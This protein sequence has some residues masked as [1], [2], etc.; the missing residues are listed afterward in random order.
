MESTHLS[1]A[2]EL[3]DRIG[4]VTAAEEWGD[5]LNPAQR[6][7]L[8]YLARANAFSRTPSNVA[9]YLCT[10][11]GT[12]SQTLKSLD[13]KGLVVRSRSAEDKRSVSYDLTNQG[14]EV[15]SRVGSFD[16]ALGSVPD[17]EARA[18]TEAL[19]TIGRHMLERRG[20]KTFGVCRTCRHHRREGDG[21]VCA[22]LGIPLTEPAT[23]Q[24]CH[25]HELPAR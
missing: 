18:F 2:R 23:D 22:L 9:A 13:R 21:A 8:A 10:T 3:L 12:A 16:A 6:S 4:R 15:L 20:F 17:S 14:R 24:L 19:E 25:E 7:A 5:E 1:R 11:R